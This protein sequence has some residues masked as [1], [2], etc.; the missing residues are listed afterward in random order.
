MSLST[1][2]DGSVPQAS[3]SAFYRATW[4]WHFY[5]GL[6]VIPFFIMLALT[7][8]VMIYDNS[9]E[10]RLGRNYAIDTTA[11]TL[12]VTQQAEAALQAY[13]GATLKMYIAPRSPDRAPVFVVKSGDTEYAVAVDP[14]KGTVLGSVDPGDTYYAWAN[15]IHGTLLIGD[16]GDRL[17]EIAA[18][19]GI[20]LLITGFYLWWPRARTPG[21]GLF[22][23]R[24]HLRGRNFW[25]DIHAV[26]GFYIGVVL[27]FFL[28]SGLS[29]AGIW[30]GKFVQAWSTFPAE[31]WD[32]VPLSDKTHAAMNH[33]PLDEVPWALEQT[34]LPASGS[35]AGIA[36][37]PEGQAVTL[38]SVAALARQIGFAGQHRINLPDGETGVYSISADSMDGDTE[39]PTG[40]RFVHI[41]RYTGKILA[42]ASF[43]DYSL[44]GKAMA[45]GIP[46]HMGEMGLWNVMLNTAYC[47]GI[48]LMCVSGAVMWWSRRPA[49]TFGL[50]PPAM[51]E[52]LPLWKGA[53]VLALFVSLAFPLAGLTL[54][55]V[56]ALDLLVLSRVPIL[57]S[58]FK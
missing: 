1:V 13:P 29:W 56:L 8:L 35:A 20:V 28:I 42:E 41:D 6:Y 30:G 26:T 52:H 37:V 46:L 53:V 19:L 10:K 38:D 49:G 32:S 23:P 31:K 24:L 48:V 2:S 11:V 7:G 14:A 17:I 16:T 5:A 34:P 4:R 39:T 27:L 58:A 9:P 54:L 45:I 21:S 22:W 25:K 51:P 40:D 43:A 12:P 18:S 33:K 47:L 3:Q 36:G 44:A 57:K 15:A 50:A 55:A